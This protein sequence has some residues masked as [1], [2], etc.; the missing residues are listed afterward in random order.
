VVRENQEVVSRDLNNVI[1]AS[2]RARDARSA[3]AI[4]TSL[5]FTQM[6]DRYSRIPE[7][8]TKTLRW[9]FDPPISKC[10]FSN[11]KTWLQKDSRDVY[12]ITGKPGSG[13]STL[14]RFLWDAPDTSEHLRQWCGALRLVCANCFF[15]NPGTQIQRSLTGLLRALLHQ[16][17]S[18]CKEMVPKALPHRWLALELQLSKKDAWIESEMLSAIRDFVR[19]VTTEARVFFIVDGL[20][21]FDGNDEQRL[22]VINL[23]KDIAQ[24]PSAKVCLSSRPWLIFQDEFDGCPSLKLEDLTRSDIRNYVRDCLGHSNMFRALQL[25]NRVECNS[26]MDEIGDRAQGVFLWVYLVVRMILNDLRDGNDLRELR[27]TLH[28]FPVDL[29]AFFGHMMR[30]LEPRYS[31]EAANLFQLVLN[32]THSRYDSH[33]LSLMTTSSVSEKDPDFAITAD[34]QGLPEADVLLRLDQANRRLNSRCKGLL[35]VSQAEA[36]SPFAAQRVDF[37]HRTVRDFLMTR[38]MS[39]MLDSFQDLKFQPVLFLCHAFLAQI[40]MLNLQI[41]MSSEHSSTNDLAQLVQQFI[42]STQEWLNSTG[43]LDSRMVD[44]LGRTLDHHLLLYGERDPPAVEWWLYWRSSTSP[45]LTLAVRENLTSYVAQALAK[46]DDIATA[47]NERPL[48]DFALRRRLIDLDPD[49][50]PDPTIVRLLIARGGNG[51]ES[52]ETVYVWA[53][54]VKYLDDIMEKRLL[55][56]KRG[57]KPNPNLDSPKDEGKTYSDWFQTTKLL[58]QNGGPNVFQLPPDYRRCSAV[59]KN[60][61]Q[62]LTLNVKDVFRAFFKAEDAQEL[63][64]L[65]DSPKKKRDQPRDKLR[66]FPLRMFSGQKK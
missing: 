57:H 59:K 66:S 25:R 27:A 44:K 35:E 7:A 62:T 37:L 60:P 33:P 1:G 23:F 29:E 28:S 38:D 46:C 42:R 64:R 17:L 63:Q 40:K 47:S 12:W 26:L 21:E 20:D 24:S 22:Q 30:T 32:N 50:A 3:D 16:L 5:Y 65:L 13:K 11:F 2:R 14:M 52:F 34:L 19:E 18:Q 8:H 10:K 15:W 49:A 53:H 4:L 9:I 31:A 36:S 48:L 56:K 58:F 54:Y 55:A 41:E 39:D 45:T 51:N 43:D 6:N 61:G